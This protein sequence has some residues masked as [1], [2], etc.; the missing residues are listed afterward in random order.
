MYSLQ[1][2]ILV[3]VTYLLTHSLT[4]SPTHS[5]THVLTYILTYLLTEANRFSASQELPRILWNRK[6]HYRIHKWPPPDHIL[7]QLD[8]VNTS[9]SY[10]WR[11]ILILYSNLGLGLQSGL[12]T[13]GFLTKYIYTPLLSLIRTTWTA[14]LI[15]QENTGTCT[16]INI[17][18]LEMRESEIYSNNVLIIR[19]NTRYR[20][21]TIGFIINY[22]VFRLVR[23]AEICCST[24]L[25]NTQQDGVTHVQ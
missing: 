11:A 15:R 21:S 3:L 24:L 5:L 18:W 14:P 2:Q 16:A 20:S 17:F 13:S 12:F 25:S 7:S 19:P 4:H 9:T 1:H 8:P 22:N 10:F 6:V 23:T